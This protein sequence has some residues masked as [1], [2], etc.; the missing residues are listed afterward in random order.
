MVP[1]LESAGCKDETG[2]LE[3]SAPSWRDY[4]QLVSLDSIT[5]DLAGRLAR[6]TS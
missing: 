3:D 5:A 1:S 2:P 4:A 6:Q